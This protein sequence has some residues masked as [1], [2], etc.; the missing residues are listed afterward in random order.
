MTQWLEANAA[1]VKGK[2]VLVGKAATIPVDFSPPAKRRDDA[3]V[4]AQFDPNNPNAGIGRGGV[5]AGRGQLPTPDPSRLTAAQV[6]EMVD[7]WLVANGALVRVNDAARQ[8]GQIRAFQNRT[9]D[10]AQ[11]VPTVVLRNEDYGRIERLL[12]DG[13]DVRLEFNIVNH[14]Y[15]EGKT[16]YNVV[17]EIPGTDKADEIVMLGGHLDSWHAAT[18]ATDNAIGATMM[19]EAARLIQTL[20]ERPRRTIRIAL[21]DAEEEGLLGSLAY[22]KQHFGTFE[23]PQPE[24][25]KLVAYF[26]IDSGTGRVR[27]ASVFGPPE[28]A[29]VVRAALAPFQDLGVAGAVPTRSRA[30][31][32]TDSTSFSNAGLAGIGLQQDPIEY[33]SH[34]WHTNLDTYERIV[35]GDARQ[36]ATVIAAAV[37]HVANREQLLPRFT[38]EQ[39]PPPVPAR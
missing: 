1:K 10:V 2:I 16:A 27:G 36:A 13:E 37:W 21:W 23:D 28:A 34:T 35:P 30:V 15:P 32:G 20:G 22:V 25:A 6:N 31:G 19:M 9:Y 33:Q 8:H 24:Y 17:A 3:Q 29:A 14:V 26:N 18:G 38:K 5:P 4:R 11:A 39:M 12:N 7:A